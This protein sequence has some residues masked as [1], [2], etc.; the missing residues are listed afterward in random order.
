MIKNWGVKGKNDTTRGDEEGSK[1]KKEEGR[2]KPR[3]EVCECVE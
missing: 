2:E 1:E 3:G